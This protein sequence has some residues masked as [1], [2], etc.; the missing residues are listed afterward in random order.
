MYGRNPR[1]VSTLLSKTQ[2]FLTQ[3]QAWPIAILTGQTQQKYGFQLSYKMGGF[4]VAS[5]K[6]LTPASLSPVAGY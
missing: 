6:S 3:L 4:S 1:A 2:G 5:D